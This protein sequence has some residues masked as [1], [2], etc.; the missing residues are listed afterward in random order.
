MWMPVCV[1]CLFVSNA[2]EPSRFV[3]S[4][5][6]TNL[7]SHLEGIDAT[8][9]IHLSK[10]CQMCTMKRMH[11]VGVG[12]LRHCLFLAALAGGFACD[13]SS[14]LAV[15]ND[16]GRSLPDVSADQNSTVAQYGEEAGSESPGVGSSCDILTDAG[17]SQG[18]YNFEA[19]ECPSLICLK[20]VVQA[21]ASPVNTTAFCSAD[22]NEDS[23][24]NGQ[25]RSSTNVLDTRCATGF[26]CAIPFVKGL[27]C[28]RKLCMC[29]DFLGPAGALTPEACKGDAGLTCDEVSH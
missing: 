18:V 13:N 22:C 12:R 6:N 29:K 21:G 23:D 3:E 26:T 25:T 14:K 9:H 4:L 5:L 17:P 8:W 1:C 28:C 27:L 7:R 10:L 11:S 16:G 20:P 15:D 24:C 19:L 2:K